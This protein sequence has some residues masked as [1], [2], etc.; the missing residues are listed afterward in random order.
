MFEVYKCFFPPGNRSSK[1]YI[2]SELM[3][4]WMC[5]VSLRDRVPSE[6][7]RA[8]AG[9][10]PIS[11]VCRRNRLRW[12]R[13]AE[14]KEDDDWVNRCTSLEVAG[15]RPRGRPRKTWMT[16]L[17]YDMRRGALSMKDARDRCLWGWRIHGA[18]W[19]IR[20]SLDTV[21]VASPIVVP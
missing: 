17:K 19:L 16:I 21:G 9:V 6:E 3:I 15:K 1:K 14:R 18:R 20:V 10:E 12:F 7:L 5:C 4:S 13:H 8:W 2:F 11:D